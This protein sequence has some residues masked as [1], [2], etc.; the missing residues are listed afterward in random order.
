MKAG[1]EPKLRGSGRSMHR[2]AREERAGGN[3]RVAVWTT[4]LSWTT[5]PALI[6]IFLRHGPFVLR[7]TNTS[8]VGP[9]FAWLL[10]KAGII[11]SP[12][13]RVDFTH[14]HRV[15][16]PGSPVFRIQA[17]VNEFTAHFFQTHRELLAGFV[18]P[19]PRIRPDRV[20]ANLRKMTGTSTYDLLALLEL[21]R[22]R[23]QTEEVPPSRIVFLSTAAI[24]ANSISLGW[25]GPDVEFGFLWSRH[26]SLLL[27]LGRG[28][29]Q[30]LVEAARP[31]RPRPTTPAAIAVAYSG[32]LDRS[33]R[34]NDLFWWWDSG[35]PAERVFLCFDR[36]DWPATTDMVAEARRLGLRCVVLDRRA[37]G[38]SPH[39][40]WRGRPGPATAFRR[41]W[42]KLRTCAWGIRRGVVGRWVACRVLDMLYWGEYLEDFLVGSNVR[43]LLHYQDSGMDY[44]SVACDMAGAA[45]IGFHWSN[46]HWPAA[47]AER[48]H[49][50]YFAW[51]SHYARV[52]ETLGSCVDHVLL[53][54]CILSEAHPGGGRGGLSHRAPLTAHG[55]TRVLALFDTSLPCDRFYEFFLRR[56]IQDPRWGLLIKPK[57]PDLPW[58]RQHL[59]E[60]QV[61]YEEALTT[62]RVQILDWWI[63]P[64][65]AAAAADFAVGV[66]INSATI[67]AALAGHRAIHLDY[68]RLHASPLAEWARFYHLGRDRL[69][70]DDPEKLWS[71]LNRFFDEPG[72]EPMLGKADEWILREIDAFR[73]DKGGAR[74]GE[75]IRWFLEGLDEG[76][77]RDNALE[78]AT[79]RYAEKWGTERVVRGLSDPSPPAGAILGGHDCTDLSR[80]GVPPVGAGLMPRR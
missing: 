63:S 8:R 57:S 43:T 69:V 50:V 23:H 70:F 78:R 53:S 65:E 77:G 29:L 72:S 73:D 2:S 20:L 22:Y 10:R 37:A 52:L 7:F 38:D 80:T 59:P 46:Q 24:L 1:G 54:G 5:V 17:G 4:L 18:Y 56:A 9:L 51:G 21:A 60:L 33:A 19:D 11:S 58:V 61:L 41:F 66:D 67:H 15:D 40:L 48:L 27:R 16:D 36:P 75:Y 12:A 42:R 64:A 31:R 45:R 34:Y 62:G 68:V 28:V 35:I 74:V 13:Q 44:W 79:R 76:L 47:Y 32:P 55:A 14:I 39:L 26:H 3:G 30:C 71:A 49:Q 25:A 6:G